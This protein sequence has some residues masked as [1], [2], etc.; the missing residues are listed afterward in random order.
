MKPGTPLTYEIFLNR[1][2]PDDR[3]FV[4]REWTS[5]MMTN[6][7]D[8]EH[9]L[10]IDGKVKWVREKAEITFNN[11]G[12]PVEAIGFAQ[13]ITERK[14]ASEKLKES[15]ERFDL[16]VKGSND[17]IW[18]W[19][20]MESDEYWWSDRLYEI[21][22]Y[23]PGEVEARVSNWLKWMHPDDSNSVMEVLNKHFEKNLPYQV[24]FR[25]QKKGGDYIWVAI[26]GES[27]RDENGKPVRM[28]GS[29]SDITD[30]KRAEEKIKKLNE[31][32]E[33]RVV[34]RTDELTRSQTA[35][36]NLVDDL[37]EKSLQLEQSAHMLETK[38]KELETFTY[39]VS[40][41]LKAPLRGIDGY[42][43]L[44]QDSY[45][46]QFDGEANTFLTNIRESALKM[47]ELINDLLEY[48]RLERSQKTVEKIKI[49]HLIQSIV[50]IYRKE[51]DAGNFDLK[52]NFDEIEIETDSKGLSIALR[53]LIENSIKFTTGKLNPTII[54]NMEE[55][56]KTW[57]LSVNDNGIGFDMKYH[58]KIF[59]IFQRLHRVEDFP[60][61]GIGLAM[62]NKAM[63][64]MNGKARAISSPGNGATFYLEVPK[65]I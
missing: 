21:L 61:T 59:D 22:G 51:L 37:N 4:N 62:V 48:S 34:E 6:N 64:Q 52:I 35:L 12:E 3:E 30:R 16:A 46:N 19:D 54:I 14:L 13:D 32:L 40:H 25:V 27:V 15:E 11:K 43:K 47:N 53:N 49:K 31:E 7:Y 24:E 9:R 39:S 33:N 23:K 26:R 57:I 10:L 65:T 28:A 38:N 2:H 36:L 44:L 55:D 29:F 20:N 56:Q 58:Q 1:V 18:D 17:A 41:D 5:K 45:K 8:I 60:G 63:Q 42:S 50:S